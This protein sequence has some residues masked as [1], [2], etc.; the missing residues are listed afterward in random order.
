MHPDLQSIQKAAEGLLYIS[1]TEAPLEVV[2]LSSANIEEIRKKFQLQANAPVEEV[3]LT[4]FF[5]NMVKTYPGDPEGEQLR[6]RRFRELLQLLEE[7][8]VNPTVYRFGKIQV[9]AFVLGEL[10]SGGVG[11]LRTRLVET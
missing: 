11:G 9:E 5:R 2:E 6:A 7:K 4:Y 10:K 8:L 1:E 3:E